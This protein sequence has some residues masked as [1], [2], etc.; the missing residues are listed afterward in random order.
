MD[1]GNLG[2]WADTILTGLFVVAG[3]VM[4][5]FIL[6]QEGKG[7]GL[8]ALGGTKAAGV[9]GVTNPIRRATVYVAILFFVLAMILGRL[10][11][12]KASLGVGTASASSTNTPGASAA[13][14]E[15]KKTE[16]PKPAETKPAEGAKTDAAKPAEKAAEGVKVEEKAPAAEVKTEEK[17]PAEILKTDEKKPVDAPKADDTKKDVPAK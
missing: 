6:L 2:Q 10:H 12:P 1:T 3:A 17:K 13:P 14:S 15:T 8:A 4:I 9:E 16:E 7:G 11:R 5:F